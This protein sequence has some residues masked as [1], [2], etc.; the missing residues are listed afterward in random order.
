MLSL[1][2]TKLNKQKKNTVTHSP[3]VDHKININYAKYINIIIIIIVLD[4]NNSYKLANY[5]NI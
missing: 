4:L 5:A 3:I 1:A 2:K